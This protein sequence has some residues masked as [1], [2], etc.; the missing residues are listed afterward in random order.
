MRICVKDLSGSGRQHDPLSVSYVVTGGWFLT[1]I[2]VSIFLCKILT[3]VSHNH[4]CLFSVYCFSF[5]PQKIIIWSSLSVRQYLF[6]L[7]KRMWWHNS[8]NFP[9]TDLNPCL[10]VHCPSFGVCKTFSAHE[11]RCVCYENCPSYQ[12]PVCT[13]NGTTYDNKCLYELSY[14]RG[15]DNNTIYHPGSCEGKWEAITI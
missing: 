2:F 6:T 9:L 10:D 3:N 13:A 4:P 1:K 11:A 8:F 14:C 15:L 5:L 7:Y 12:D